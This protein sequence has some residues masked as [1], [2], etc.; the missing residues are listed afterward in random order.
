MAGRSLFLFLVLYSCTELFFNCINLTSRD[1][2]GG[3]CGGVTVLV[4]DGIPYNGCTL[5][6]TLQAKAVT[7]STSKT[8][9]ICSLYLTPSENLNIVLLSCFII[10]FD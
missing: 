6:T 4:R 3:A 2:A 1:I 10:L 8:I 5:H 9:T 7:R